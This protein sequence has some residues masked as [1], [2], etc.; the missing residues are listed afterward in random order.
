MD[1]PTFERG[2]LD[3][4]DARIAY[5]RGG[6]GPPLVVAHGY[7]D[8][9]ACRRPLLDALAADH[10]V[11]AYDARG[12]G[13][14]TAPATGYGIDGRV[15]DLR[16][17]VDGLGLDRPA[18]LGH[19]M[20]GNTVAHAVARGLDARRVVLVDPAGML[21]DVATGAAAAD[22]MRRRVAAW[23][24]AP[25]AAVVAEYADTPVPDRLADARKRLSPRVARVRE[26]GYPAFA[27]AAPD[28][29]APTLVLRADVDAATRER[30]RRLLARAPDARVVHVADA[31]H[32]VV[33]DRFEA[34]LAEVRAFLG[35]A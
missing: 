35:G 12:H 33:R 8:D 3:A 23:D 34:A 11:V 20:G 17:V 24:R 31:G 28:L 15:A 14:S 26:H 6:E 19:S 30:D 13:H 4:R 5:L 9:A 29:D 2:R 21:D 16:A 22:E 32:T 27:G 1:D 10:E 18:L 25:R 7:T